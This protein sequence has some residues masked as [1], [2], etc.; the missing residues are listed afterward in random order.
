[1]MVPTDRMAQ[2]AK[3]IQLQIDEAKAELGIKAVYYRDQMKIPT[4]PTVCVEPGTKRRDLQGVPRA[5]LVTMEIILLVYLFKIGSTLQQ[6]GEDVDTLAE[7]LEVFLHKDPQMG[8]QAIHSYMTSVE[9]GY[10]QRDSSS[11]RTVRMTFE[12]TS[13]VQL[14]LGGV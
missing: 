10:A 4:T 6:A 9:Y 11:F 2:M 13:K 14:P 5:T 12:T 7:D 1:M 3:Y 8:G